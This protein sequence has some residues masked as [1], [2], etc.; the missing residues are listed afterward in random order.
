MR[1][2]VLV[3]VTLV[4]L[5]APA[6]GQD[7]VEFVSRDDRFTITFPAQPTI[8]T[9]TYT[10]QFGAQLPARLYAATVGPRRFSVLVADYANIEAILT[11][12]A[13]ACPPGAETCLGG[14]GAGSATG[15]GYWKADFYGAVIHATHELLKR[16]ARLTYLGWNSADFV[17]GNM[18]SLV[19]RDGSRT[20]AAVY[21]HE[22][23]LYLIESTVP[24]GYP[25]A[26]F[27]QQSVGW[28][29]ENGRSIRYQQVY[30]HGWF[31]KPP[32]QR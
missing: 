32:T 16:D 20:S 29:D 30:H 12:K 15:A 9:T 23:T 4:A 3:L 8:T 25:D 21:M 19:N 14:R 1:L 22:T 6:V 11:E 17:E 27:F 24:E 26:S 7:W 28:L 31:P 2:K 13:K 5:C 18:V 10:S